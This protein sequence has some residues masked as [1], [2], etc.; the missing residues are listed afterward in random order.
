[1]P[2]TTEIVFR[3]KATLTKVLGLTIPEDRREFSHTT[4]FK[5]GRAANEA[6]R[7]FHEKRTLVGPGS[8]AAYDLYNMDSSETD[9]FGDLITFAAVKALHIAAD[10]ANVSNIIIGGATLNSWLG[11]FGADTDT[12]TIVPG[13]ELL[14][15]ALKT[16]YSVDDATRMLRVRNGDIGNVTYSLTIIGVD[17]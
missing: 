8:E 12:L 14:L 2:L 6:N 4:S 9:A 16:E 10:S 7:M 5:N 1:M 17:Q 11:P 3:M 15:T 13:G